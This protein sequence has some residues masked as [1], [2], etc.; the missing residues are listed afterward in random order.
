MNYIDDFLKD[1]G[2]GNEYIFL[3]KMESLGIARKGV[4]EETLANI[5]SDP[6]DWGPNP[7]DGNDDDNLF[8]LFQPKMGIAAEI[9]GKMGDLFR[10]KEQKDLYSKLLKRGVINPRSVDFDFLDAVNVNLREKFSYLQL[11]K[12]CSDSTEAYAELTAYFYSNLSFLDANRFSFSVKDQD[13]VVDMNMLADVLEV[14]RGR[15]QTNKVSIA[16]ATLELVKDRRTDEKITYLRMGAFNILLH[17]I[18]INCLRPKSTSKTDVSSSEAKLM[19]AILFG[20]RFSLPHTVMFHMYRAMMKDRGQLPYPSLVTKLFRHLNIQP[21]QIFCVRPCDHMVVGLKM[22]T[23]MRLKELSKELEKFKEKTP[24]KS[25]QISSAAKRKGKEP[26]VAPSKRRRA[27]LVE[28]E[29]D[30]ED[31]TISALA[32]KNLS[33]PV[34]QKESE[35]MTK[36]AEEKEE[37]EI[38]AEKETE[39]ERPEEERREEGE[40]EEHSSPPVGMKTGG[41]QEKGVKSS[42]PD[43]SE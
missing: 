23:K 21:P 7:V 27:L 18:V 35:Q 41:D 33:R 13:Y 8:S 17:K 29:D 40:H 31:I 10:S 24:A 32:L 14:E 5:P 39:E 19:Y 16:R 36:E 28:D 2:H 30:E 3:R 22:V 25:H 11:E 20:K 26:M 34:P 15:Y 42:C 37:E 6:R 9:Q 12:F 43:A 38:E 1:K 4:A